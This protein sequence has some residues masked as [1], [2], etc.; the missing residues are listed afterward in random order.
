MFFQH[1]PYGAESA[2]KSWGHAV[3]Q[4]LV[5]WEHLPIALTPNP[6]SYD[7]DG[8]YSGCC[9]VHNGVPTII[10]TGVRPEVQCIAVS[11]D[12]MRTWEK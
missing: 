6:G 5:H 12:G 1:N 2:N 10:Y 4:D 8:V 11:Y 9:V 7:K 3:S